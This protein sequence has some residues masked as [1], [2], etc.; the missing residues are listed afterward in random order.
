MDEERER[1][2]ERGSYSHQLY[3][4]ICVC[5]YGSLY[6]SFCRFPL[7]SALLSLFYSLS[8]LFVVYSMIGGFSSQLLY[9]MFGGVSWVKPALLVSECVCVLV[10]VFGGVLWVKSALLVCKH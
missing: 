7:P 1:G 3:V 6:S 5:V 4:Y 8:H 10:C 9:K 2:R